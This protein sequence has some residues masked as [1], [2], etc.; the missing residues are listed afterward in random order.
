MTTWDDYDAATVIDNESEWT[1]A[2]ESISGDI[3][4]KRIAEY[5]EPVTEIEY[6][7]TS[8]DNA[9]DFHH[10]RVEMLE[11]FDGKITLYAFNQDSGWAN[12]GDIEIY[13]SSNQLLYDTPISSG[14]KEKTLEV[15]LQEGVEYYIGH[16]SGYYRSDDTLSEKSGEFFSVTGSQL[17]YDNRG[18]THSNRGYGFYKIDV[19][20]ESDDADASLSQPEAVRDFNEDSNDDGD[21]ILAD[22]NYYTSDPSGYAHDNGYTHDQI[23]LTEGDSREYTLSEQG[24]TADLNISIRDSTG[25]TSNTGERVS[26]SIT[27]EFTVAVEY[28]GSEI[29]VTDEGGDQLY[30]TSE[31]G[32]EK[33]ISWYEWAGDSGTSSLRLTGVSTENEGGS[34]ESILWA[35][36]IEGETEVAEFNATQESDVPPEYINTRIRAYDKTGEPID[37][38][39]T[40]YVP[41]DQQDDAVGITGQQFSIEY[42]FEPGYEDDLA[43]I[44]GYG[45]AVDVSSFVETALATPINSSSYPNQP[46]TTVTTTSSSITT[47]TTSTPT[48]STAESQTFA[49]SSTTTSTSILNTAQRVITKEATGSTLSVFSTPTVGVG[50]KILEPLAIYNEASTETTTPSTI[51]SQFEGLPE[52]F[53]QINEDVDRAIER[54]G[55][56]VWEDEFNDETNTNDEIV[57]DDNHTLFGLTELGNTFYK[58][59]SDGTIDWV[60]DLSDNYSGIAVGDEYIIAGRDE[61][62]ASSHIKINKDRGDRD[63]RHEDIVRGAVETNDGSMDSSGNY[64]NIN[65]REEVKKV[66]TDNVE[67]WETDVNESTHIFVGPE[68]KYVY[69]TGSNSVSK[70]DVEDGT[71]VE[72]RTL[73]SNLSPEYIDSDGILYGY[74]A[75]DWDDDKILWEYDSDGWDAAQPM[76]TGN[77]YVGT[78]SDYN[79][80]EKLVREYDKNT[81]NIKNTIE[82]ETD[83]D[84]SDTNT[85][86]IPD[87]GTFPDSWDVH[88]TNARTT[89]SQTSAISTQSTPTSQLGNVVTASGVGS[90]T[91]TSTAGGFATSYAMS[92]TTQG[93]S[94]VTQP[95]QMSTTYSTASPTTTFGTTVEPYGT[96]GIDAVADYVSSTA[97]TLLVEVLE[98]IV[99]AEKVTSLSSAN[100]AAASAIATPS[101]SEL[102][103]SAQ[104]NTIDSFAEASIDAVGGS[105]ESTLSDILATGGVST[106]AGRIT[107]TTVTTIVNVESVSDLSAIL[108]TST[109]STTSPSAFVQSSSQAYGLGVTGVPLT[110]D[111][112]AT[113]GSIASP[114]TATTSTQ[115]AIQF[116]SRDV[117]IGDSSNSLAFTGRTGNSVEID[118]SSK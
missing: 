74:G 33:Y 19:A 73:D 5:D 36:D 6:Y 106:I 66:N 70:L 114:I 51:S 21:G 52:F 22:G 81:G 96:T 72:T 20:K 83:T 60:L 34:W 28:T 16:T 79:G 32:D 95:N 67:E 18:S 115:T 80:S 91:S 59:D 102:K 82:I 86:F 101:T 23:P 39:D 63:S 50:N 2:T 100:I 113:A 47:N 25:T 31:S 92:S 3:E 69:A 85:V 11:D 118:Y 15:S 41:F 110:I 93:T 108:S 49:L 17:N 35:P 103:S 104:L 65:A 27:G 99:R 109:S 87:V 46:T 53:Y 55:D 54:N 78:N 97:T 1:D 37:G 111:P 12:D 56:V 107:P 13:N 57:V 62:T 68:N 117:L 61:G 90:S 43:A 112:D 10:W 4:I 77:A 75:Y 94:S 48:I 89:V 64:Y 88:S 9:S 84:E 42:Q 30:S 116:V 44:E 38:E 45:I 105:I 7:T 24:S 8:S 29:I 71:V 14:D 98:N 58:L 40:G 26:S 76:P